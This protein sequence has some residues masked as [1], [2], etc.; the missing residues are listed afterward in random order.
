M[1]LA[2][3]YRPQL[4]NEVVG[5]RMPSVILPAMIEQGILSQT[6]LFT[7]PSGVGKTSMA[8]IV[9]AELNPDAKDDVHNGIHPAVLEIDAASNGSVAAIRDLK[10]QLLYGIPGHR[11]V[12]IDEAHSMSKEAFDVFLNMLESPPDMVT[13]IL[14]TTESHKIPRTIRHRCDKYEFKKAS[15]DDILM[16]LGHVVAEEKINV[17][18]ELLDLIAHRSEGSYR[19]SLMI[20]GQVAVANITTIEEYNELQGE[21]DYGPSLILS[22]LGGS[23]SAL[24]KLEDILRYTNPEEVID[25]TV[26]ILRDLMLL[27]GGIELKYSGKALESRRLI[28]KKLGTQDILKAIQIIWDL[29]TKL[30]AGDPVRGLE[31]AYAMLGEILKQQE[32]VPIVKPDTTEV[33]SLED[34]QAFIG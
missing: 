9:A 19:E 6:L 10:T 20:L 13:F 3:K 31:M 8:R 25:R 23:A 34:M 28:A 4:F 15:I 22:A 16:R 12:I 17:S 1:N 33:M 27:R 26:E 21:I 14:I 5:Q 11:V 32:L 30:S 29:Q 24:S 2:L 18:T 7:G